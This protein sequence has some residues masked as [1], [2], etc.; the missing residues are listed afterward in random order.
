MKEKK[1]FMEGIFKETPEGPKPY[2]TRCKKCGMTFFPSESICTGC[3][4]EEMDEFDLPKEG[5]L[6]TYTVVYR[7]VN[8][9]PIPHCIGEIIYPEEKLDVKGVLKVN[10][11]EDLEKGNEFKIGSKVELIM[12]TLWE[13]E[14]TEIIGYKYRIVE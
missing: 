10:N 9:Y 8:K 4:S 7:P 12:D 6:K 2:A 11:P 1:L 3:L 13:E 14:D 5:V